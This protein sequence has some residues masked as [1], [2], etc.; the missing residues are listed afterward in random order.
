ME[1]RGGGGAIQQNE[2]EEE[3]ACGERPGGRWRAEGGDS[4]I[5]GNP[6]PS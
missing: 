1:G 6:G 5:T 2:W 3:E 4:G